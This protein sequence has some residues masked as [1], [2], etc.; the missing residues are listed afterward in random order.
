MHTINFIFDLLIRV[1]FFK[2]KIK[3]IGKNSIHI[4]KILKLLSPR[5]K[6]GVTN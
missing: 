3:L 5:Y 1:N 2:N 4:F 6:G